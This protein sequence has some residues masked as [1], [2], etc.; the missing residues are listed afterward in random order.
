MKIIGRILGIDYGTRRIGLAL[1]DV[2]QRLASPCGQVEAR[3]QPGPDTAALV[4]WIEAGDHAVGG[5]VVGLPLNM[6]GSDGP[7]AVLTRRFAAELERRAA[8]PVVLWDE[9]LSTFQAEAYLAAAELSK[10]AR[11]R[12]R[13]AL[14]AQVILQSYLDAATQSP[15]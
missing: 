4:R 10:A 9:R 12:R 11:K 15:S 1:S 14:A 7:Q 3:G 5:F 6:N 8:R 13:D 2:R